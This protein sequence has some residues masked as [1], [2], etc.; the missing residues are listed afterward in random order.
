MNT[1]NLTPEQN[2]KAEL[3]SEL[4]KINPETTAKHI[5]EEANLLQEWILSTDRLQPCSTCDKA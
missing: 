5:I 4:I 2:L 3:V 1:Q